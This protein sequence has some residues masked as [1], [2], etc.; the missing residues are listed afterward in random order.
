[1]KEK[2]FFITFKRLSLNKTKQIFWENESCSLTT[3]LGY[4]LD[5]ET[6]KHET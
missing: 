5:T 6:E 3:K 2:T 4:F 1:M